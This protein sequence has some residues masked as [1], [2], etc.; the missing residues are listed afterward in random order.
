V[1]VSWR[2]RHNDGASCPPWI[3]L[4][5]CEQAIETP[6]LTAAT[7]LEAIKA[8]VGANSDHFTTQDIALHM[9]VEEYSVRSTFSWLTRNKEIEIVPGVRTKRYRPETS[10][11][12]WNDDWY[13]VSVYQVVEKAAA[14]DFNALNRAFG[15][16]R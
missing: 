16:G 12:R 5:T 6:H 10:K 2:A 1:I 15:F 7:V 13:S 9:G 11:R 14:A 4:M 3:S 8:Y